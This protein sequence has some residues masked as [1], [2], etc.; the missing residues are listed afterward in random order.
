M[1]LSQN[2]SNYL[3]SLELETLMMDVKDLQQAM[4]HEVAIL[5]D[6]GNYST[7][8]LNEAHCVY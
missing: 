5:S 6:K 3:A 1:Q 4:I 7:R 8:P 2:E